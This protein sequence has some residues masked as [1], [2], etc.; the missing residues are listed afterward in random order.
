MPGMHRH[1]L[2]NKDTKKHI[3]FQRMVQL[4]SAVLVTGYIIPLY[5]QEHNV[6]GEFQVGEGGSGSKTFEE[7]KEAKAQGWPNSKGST[8]EKEEPI[9]KDI[10]EARAAAE[11]GWV[12]DSNGGY[13]IPVGE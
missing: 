3:S 11:A 6:I 2:K 10:D 12:G 7:M 9:F 13:Y 5:D 8:L 1:R 4:I